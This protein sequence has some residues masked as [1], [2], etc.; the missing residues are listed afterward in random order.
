MIKAQDY[1]FVVDDVERMAEFT[2]V[3]DSGHLFQMPLIPLQKTYQFRSGMIGEPKYYSMIDLSLGC[4]SGDP[5]QN[6]EAA[7]GHLFN[8]SQV[9]VFE[10]RPDSF[11]RGGKIYDVPFYVALHSERQIDKGRSPSHSFRQG[12]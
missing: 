2:G 9:A 6:R 4:V 12:R 1:D 5:P 8:S 3:S 11:P 7:G 10:V